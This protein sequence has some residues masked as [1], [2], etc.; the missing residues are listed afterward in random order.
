M[1]IPI[2]CAV[3]ANIIIQ[4]LERLIHSA[5]DGRVIKEGIKTVIVGKPNENRH[6]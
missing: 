3:Q 2:L 1:D 5:D 4:E 6:F